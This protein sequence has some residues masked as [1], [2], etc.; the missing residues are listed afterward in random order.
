MFFYSLDQRKGYTF[1]SEISSGFL[2]NQNE[3]LSGNDN[4]EHV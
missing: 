3:L 4:R 2:E 1:K